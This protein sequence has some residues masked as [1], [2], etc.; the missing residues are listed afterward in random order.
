MT[1]EK[2]V[3]ELKNA[4]A[5]DLKSVVLY[6]SAAT[7]DHAG[8]NSDYNVLVVVNTLGVEQLDS[9]SGSVKKWTKAGNTSPLLFTPERLQKSADA[10]PIEMLDIKDNNKVLYGDDVIKD[11]EISKQN[12]RLELEHELKGKLIQLR[13]QFMLTE[14]KPKL[15]TELMINS[16]STFLVL[17]RSSLRLFREDVPGDKRQALKELG[18]QLKIDMSVFMTIRKLK[19]RELKIKGINPIGLFKTYLSKVEQVVDMVDN[20]IHK[21]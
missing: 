12:L 14:S 9:I 7:G 20:Y 13:Q 5:E 19:S 15:V 21:S 18:E 17:F 10:F 1:P 16:I 11:M 4:L 8:K 2:L 3:D 6:G